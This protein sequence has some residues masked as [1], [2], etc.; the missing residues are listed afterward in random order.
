MF[1]LSGLAHLSFFKSRAELNKQE[2]SLWTMCVISNCI[3]T[4]PS[5]VL[6][7]PILSP[8]IWRNLQKTAGCFR[9]FCMAAVFFAALEGLLLKAPN[10]SIFEKVTFDALKCLWLFPFCIGSLNGIVLAWARKLEEQC[11]YWHAFRKLSWN[12]VSGA[13][14]NHLP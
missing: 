2:K 9:H 11:R 7:V 14:S 12:L 4:S 8:Y 6:Y 10:S 1:V 13:Q 3:Y 5:E